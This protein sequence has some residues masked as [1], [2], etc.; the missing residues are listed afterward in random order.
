MPPGKEGK[1]TLQIEHTENLQ[2]EVAKGAQVVTNDPANQKFQLLLRA[3]VKPGPKKANPSPSPSSIA[4]AG[5]SKSLGPFSVSPSDRWATGSLTGISSSGTLS[6]YNTGTTPVHIKQIKLQSSDFKA[7][8]T[9]IQPGKRY[10]VLVE[11]NPLLKPG[12]YNQTLTLVTD[13]KTSPEI[14]IQLAATIFPRVF[15]TPGSLTIPTAPRSTDWSTISLP[16]IYVRR[17]RG[18]G[19]VVASVS[20][21]LPFLKLSITTE[22]AGQVYRI[23][24]RIDKASIP[25]PGPTKGKIRIETNDPETP[26]LE[27][28]VQ[29]SFT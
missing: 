26:V 15:V 21:N 23:D 29:G 1:V 24:V 9:T 4:I 5:A 19:L 27:V 7:S 25:A 3:Y 13:S 14:E 17:I 20:T 11:T 18:G 16:S 8:L 12:Q 28:E 22:T 2:G 6:F 10:Q